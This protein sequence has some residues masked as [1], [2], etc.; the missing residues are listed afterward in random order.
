MWLVS[1]YVV[2]KGPESGLWAV[3]WMAKE[4][5]VAYGPSCG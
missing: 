4:A 2:D 1:H 5:S 3:M